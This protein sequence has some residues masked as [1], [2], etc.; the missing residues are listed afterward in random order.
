MI[1]SPDLRLFVLLLFIISTQNTLQGQCARKTMVEEYENHFLGTQI[2]LNDLQWDGDPTACI[3][4]NI[5]NVSRQ[6]TLDRI[7]YYR[8]LAGLSTTVNFDSNLTTMCQQAALMMHSNNDLSHE[9]PTNWSCFSTDGMTAAGKS[10]LALGAHSSDAIALYMIDPGSNNGAVGHRRWILYSR[11]KDFGMGST[12]RANALYVIHNRIA[13]PQNISYIAYP[14]EGFFP[15]PLLPDRWSVSVP[16]GNFDIAS[17]TLLD[18]ES[19]AL[20]TKVEPVKDGYGDNTLVWEVEQGQ[21]NR[22]LDYDQDYH[23]T[24]KDVIVKGDTLTFDYTVTV[25]PVKHPPT[26]QENLT[27]SESHCA[28]LNEQTTSVANQ[29]DHGNRMIISPNPADDQLH[30]SLPKEWDGMLISMTIMDYT[31][32]WITQKE[33]I[34]NASFDTS[35]YPVGLYLLVVQ[36]QSTVRYERFVIKH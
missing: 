28:C 10:N 32:K 27:W 11:A 15:A 5:S 3:A 23:V 30:I 18:E 2:L 31:G 21:I 4:G 36:N 29:S 12:N 34:R 1:T 16:G 19:D 8:R 26:C 35:N 25:S 9:P 17:I 24:V 20:M 14:P 33:V 22:Y 7:N 13:P 6:K